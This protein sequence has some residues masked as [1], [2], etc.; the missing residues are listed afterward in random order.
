[1]SNAAPFMKLSYILLFV[2]LAFIVSRMSNAYTNMATELREMRI[3]C[4]GESFKA[5]DKVSLPFVNDMKKVSSVL[6]G[7]ANRYA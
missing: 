5:K 4:M 7:M 2:I 3:K 6:Q 1:M